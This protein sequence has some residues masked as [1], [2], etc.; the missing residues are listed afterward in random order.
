MLRGYGDTLLDKIRRCY[1]LSLP[2]PKYTRHSRTVVAF[3]L[4]LR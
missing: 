1:A 4:T 2:L 3:R